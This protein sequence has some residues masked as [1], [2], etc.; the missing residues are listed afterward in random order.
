MLMDDMYDF[1]NMMN[2]QKFYLAKTLTFE[3]FSIE[4]HVIFTATAMALEGI[5]Q[6]PFLSGP[7]PIQELQRLR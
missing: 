3:S 4:V 7:S 6:F 5:S 2:K 1:V